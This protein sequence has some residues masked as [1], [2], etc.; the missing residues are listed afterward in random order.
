[1]KGSSDKGKILKLIRNSL[2]D[3]T[4]ILY[5]NF[6]LDSDIYT[7]T[8]DDPVM[9]FAESIINN[10]GK[11]IYC[12]DEKDML[13]RLSVLIQNRSWSSQIFSYGDTLNNFLKTNKIEAKQ[14]G[15]NRPVVGISLCNGISARNGLITITSREIKGA[16]YF[17]LPE[18]FVI[19][20]FTSQIYMD[21]KTNLNLLTND[22]PEFITTLNSNYLLREE[23]KELYVFTIENIIQT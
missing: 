5:S 16:K 18:V 17:K 10:G 14:I 15:E 19:I 1:M 21:L 2:L 9:V 20:A 3:K 12:K 8:K 23:I 7:S 6:D 22:M 11:F 4:D 13:N